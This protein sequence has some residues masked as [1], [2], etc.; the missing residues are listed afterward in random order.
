MAVWNFTLAVV[1]NDGAAEFVGDARRDG[2]VG[3]RCMNAV[4]LIDYALSA[5]VLA[6]AVAHAQEAIVVEGGNV[7]GLEPDDLVTL[8]EIGHESGLGWHRV[9]ALA[10]SDGD[11]QMPLPVRRLS[12]D[13]PLWSWREV[14]AW[15]AAR[16]LVSK[17]TA[18]FAADAYEINAGLMSNWQTAVLQT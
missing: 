2:V 10:N 1:Q 12:S 17:E 11:E 6:T 3:T 9:H 7:I 16:E 18:K 14:S 5:D 8:Q 13:R 4:W 15:L